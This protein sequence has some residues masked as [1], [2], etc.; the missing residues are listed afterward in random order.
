MN[1]ETEVEHKRFSRAALRSQIG[2]DDLRTF[3]RVQ[4]GMV[5]GA[6]IASVLAAVYWGVIAADR[7][8]SEA[9]V[10]VQ[11]TDGIEPQDNSG[12][13]SRSLLR[14]GGGGGPAQM[15]QL[16]LRDHLL[17][18]DMLEKLNAKLN[19]RQHYS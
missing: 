17:S 18:V 15:E 10:V 8:V 4:R 13:G 14:G 19:L 11:R 9:H 7:Y 1:A 2:G 5:R 16:L 12:G 3:K 6:V